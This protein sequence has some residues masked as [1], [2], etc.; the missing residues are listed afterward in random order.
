MQVYGSE[1]DRLLVARRWK[2]NSQAFWLSN[3]DALAKPVALPLPQGNWKKVLDS[4]DRAWGG[5]G[6]VLPD[7]IDGTRIDLS[8]GKYGFALFVMDC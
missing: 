3:F 8:I 7:L 2:E 4:D 6:A 1:S 5:P